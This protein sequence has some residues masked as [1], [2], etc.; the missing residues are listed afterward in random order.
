[1]QLFSARELASGELGTGNW[2]LRAE[3]WQAENREVLNEKWGQRTLTWCNQ[4]N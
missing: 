1:M 3:S 2:E 4:R